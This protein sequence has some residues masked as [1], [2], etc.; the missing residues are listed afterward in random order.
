MKTLIKMQFDPEIAKDIGVGEAIMYAN[1]EYW[2]G[3]NEFNNKNFYDGCYWTY[4]SKKAYAKLF[5]FWTE[6]QIRTILDNLRKKGYIKTGN[7]NKAKYDKTLWYA[8]DMPK[9]ADGRTNRAKGSDQSGRPIPNNKPNNK[10]SI[11]K[12]N[13]F[14][15][16]PTNQRRLYMEDKLSRCLEKQENT[17]LEEFC[18]YWTEANSDGGKQKWQFEKTFDI[19]RRFRTWLANSKNWGSNKNFKKGRFS[20]NPNKTNKPTSTKYAK[21][22][23]T[24]KV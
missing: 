5:P 19:V 13:F 18:S 23:T 1:I 24:V 22:I 16:L 6:K 15:D 9:R 4:N 21:F 20:Y 8:I 3:R 7:Y 17:Q 14:F 10:L 12:K 2:C 11:Y